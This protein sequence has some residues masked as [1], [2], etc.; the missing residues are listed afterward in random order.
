M[1]HVRADF[2]HTPQARQLQK[3]LSSISV[4]CYC[5]KK[6]F[7]AILDL[8]NTFW[9]L[10]VA[11]LRIRTESWS[12]NSHSRSRSRSLLLRFWWCRPVRNCG[13][14]WQNCFHDFDL[15]QNKNA[16]VMRI[17]KGEFISQRTYHPQHQQASN[18]SSTKGTR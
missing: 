7:N 10:N 16:K 8:D 17:S 11:A 12:I 2:L 6:V 4:R 1:W 18:N 9:V 15:E 3:R 14:W 5:T 13:I